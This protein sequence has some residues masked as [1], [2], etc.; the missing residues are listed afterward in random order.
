[1]Q[2]IKYRQLRA[3]VWAA[4]LGSFKEAAERLSVSQAAFSALIKELEQDVGVRLLERTTRRCRPTEAGAALEARLVPL[5]GEL[6]DAYRH[7]KDLASGERGRLAIAALPSL[8][9]GIVT[10]ALGDYRRLYPMVQIVLREMKNAEVFDAVRDGQVELGVASRLDDSPAGLEFVPLTTDRLVFVVPEGHPLCGERPGWKV[11]ERFPMILM[12]TGTAERAIRASGVSVTP[13]F[14][15]E[16]MATALSMVRHGLGISIVPSSVLFGLN[17]AG[18][19]ALRIAGPLAV[20]RLGVFVR[21]GRALTAPAS[22]FL[23]L[24]REVTPR[25]LTGMEPLGGV[26]AARAAGRR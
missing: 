3:F 21:E 24:L 16:H 13:A 1:M 17:M 20:R 12:R 11:L 15:V 25:E 14:E 9:F 8:S 23:R 22:I 2:N 26:Q 5:L 7:V 6:E 4:E 19:V 10:R 18:L